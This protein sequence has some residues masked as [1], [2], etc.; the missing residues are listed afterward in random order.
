MLGG[1][2]LAGW[3]ILTTAVDGEAGCTSNNCK[4]I[5]M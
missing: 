3:R 2:W 5:S 1:S 4:E